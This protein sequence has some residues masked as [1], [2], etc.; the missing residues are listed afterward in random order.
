MSQTSTV[1]VAYKGDVAWVTIDNP[2]PVGVTQVSNQGTVSTNET[3]DEPTDDPDTGSDDD[4][5]NTTVTAAPV[6]DAEKADALHIDADG[7]GGPSPG[8]TIRYT[9]AINNTG[10]T[11]ATAVVFTDPIPT[12]TTVVAG[13]VTTTQ[14]TV[15]SEDPV[16]VTI[17]DIAAGA[18]VAIT[19]DVLVEI[20]DRQQ[21]LAHLD[22]T[23]S[24]D[25]MLRGQSFPVEL[26]SRTDSG[27]IS[28][29]FLFCPA[30]ISGQECSCRIGHQH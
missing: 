5:T 1:T 25:A 19:F 10:N 17:G 13:S 23:S 11:A 27:E 6:L 2:L 3:P 30:L 22:V 14:G 8:D 21:L 29:E 15:N 26:R 18:T 12:Y 28:L 24:V 9:V 4:P 20:Q 16:D 7:S